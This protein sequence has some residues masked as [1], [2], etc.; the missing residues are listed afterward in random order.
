MRGDIDFRLDRIRVPEAAS[1]L[2]WTTIL[3]CIARVMFGS[4]LVTGLHT[5]YNKVDQSTLKGE[6]QG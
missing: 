2:V 6:F 1:H 4:C 5:L 3:F